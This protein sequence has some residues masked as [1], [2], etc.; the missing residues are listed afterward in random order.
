MAKRGLQ[1]D[2][3]VMKRTIIGVAVIVTLGSALVF[4]TSLYLESMQQQNNQEM[5]KLR[6]ISQKYYQAEQELQMVR[7]YLPRFKHL[8]RLG[9]ISG[10]NR[11]SWIEALRQIADEKKIPVM[12]YELKAQQLAPEAYPIDTG[13]FGLF[14]S[15]MILNMELFLRRN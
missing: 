6:E 8:Q 1:I 7:T 3:S 10:E 5:Q 4:G 14:M 13:E 2:W 15:E 12:K 11:L 9:F